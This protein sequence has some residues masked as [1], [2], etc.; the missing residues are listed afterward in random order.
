MFITLLGIFSHP[1]VLLV[2]LISFSI[3]AAWLSRRFCI[4]VILPAIIYRPCLF[5][6]S[7]FGCTS[8]F[9]VVLA[10]FSYPHNN[11]LSFNILKLFINV[12]LIYNREFFFNTLKIFVNLV[13]PSKDKL[14]DTSHVAP[15][16]SKS[17]AVT[18]NTLF[19]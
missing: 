19:I 1:N 11:K 7:Y 12:I 4:E 9:S 18:S 6:P 5:S 3:T 16:R 2:C 10:K 8:K 17:P 15:A 13:Y 14:L